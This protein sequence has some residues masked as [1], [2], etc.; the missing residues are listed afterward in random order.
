VRYLLFSR[1]T[2][3]WLALLAVTILSWEVA[4]GPSF[5]DIRYVNATIVAIAFAKV[6]YVILDFMELCDAPLPMRVVS[7]GWVA[8]VGS[9]LI[10]MLWSAGQ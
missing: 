4:H 10:A 3:I 1:V 9:T 6:R 7:E 5:R 8:V 2:F